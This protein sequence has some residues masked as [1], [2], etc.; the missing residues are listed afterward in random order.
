MPIIVNEREIYGYTAEPNYIS[1]RANQVGRPAD[2]LVE[3]ICN[4]KMKRYLHSLLRETKLIF[5]V[6]RATNKTHITTRMNNTR[7]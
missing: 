6:A 4:T 1:M 2:M 5:V 7:L 3:K